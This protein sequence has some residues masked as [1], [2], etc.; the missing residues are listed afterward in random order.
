MSITLKVK[1]EVLK[2]KATAITSSIQ[3]IERELGE[4]GRVVLGTKNYWEGDASNQHQS[5]YKTIQEDVPTVLKRLKE[6]PKDLLTMA[7]L[8]DA[9]EEANQQLANKL[10][11]NIIV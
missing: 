1:P 9:S 7:E 6:H 4:I 11:E 10:P 5:Y 8:Y 3:D 2:T